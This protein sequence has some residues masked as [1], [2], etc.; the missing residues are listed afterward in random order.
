MAGLDNKISNII[1]TKIPNKILQQLYLRSEKGSSYF[2]DT[3]NLVYLS[4]KTAWARLVSSVNLSSEDMAYFKNKIEID[5]SKPEDLAKNYVLFAGTSKYLNNKYDL[6]SGIGID[7]SYGMLGK[8]EIKEYGYKP[9]PGMTEV[10]IETQGRLGSI[11]SANI[12]FRC[13]DKDQLDIMDALYFKLGFSMFLEWGHTVYFKSDNPNKLE[14]SELESIDPF[15]ANLSKETIQERIAE[16]NRKTEGNYDAMLGIVTNFNYSY[17]Q[18]GGFDCTLKLMS[19]GIL[20]DTI[21]INNTGILPN[22][23]KEEIKLYADTLALIEKKAQEEEARQNAANNPP[24]TVEQIPPPVNFQNVVNEN[25]SSAFINYSSTSPRKSGFENI[26]FSPKAKN[27]DSLLGIRKLQ[28]L[29]PIGN[30][31]YVRTTK[32]KFDTNQLLNL[33]NQFKTKLLDVRNWESSENGLAADTWDFSYNYVSRANYNTYNVK[34]RAE[35]MAKVDSN[36]LTKNGIESILSADNG[37]FEPTLDTTANKFGSAIGNPDNEYTLSISKPVALEYTLKTL[38][39]DRLKN[40][41]E[42]LLGINFKVTYEIEK[43]VQ[44]KPKTNAAQQLVYEG[45]KVIKV[46]YYQEMEF[47]FN[48]TFLLSSISTTSLIK[49][50]DDFLANQKKIAEQNKKQ[51]QE[52]PPPVEEPSITPEQSA[53]SISSQSSLELTL[54]SIQLHSLNK[55]INKIQGSPDL[56]IGKLVYKSEIWNPNDKTSSGQT[57]LS[58]IFSKGVFTPFI[59]SIVN[60]EIANSEEYKEYISKPTPSDYQRLKVQAAYGFASAIMKNKLDATNIGLLKPVNFKELLTAYVVPYEISQEI[61]NGTQANHPVYIPFG[62]LLMILNHCSIVYDKN[63]VKQDQVIKPLV[64]IDFNPNH[65][66]CL[67][68]PK[69]I[70][71]NPFKILIPCEATQSDFAE[72]FDPSVLDQNKKN[73]KSTEGNTEVQPLFLTQQ[74]DDRLSSQIPT[75]RFDEQS[76]NST[77]AYRGKIMNIL[78]S[79]DY[80]I[81]LIQEFSNKEDYNNVYLKQFLDKIIEDINKYTGNFNYFRVSYNDFANTYQIIDDQLVPPP[82]SD[83][84]II[85]PTPTNSNPNDVA[86]FSTLPLVG[87]KSIAK[88]LSITTNISSKLSNMIA[89]SA[90]ANVEDKSVLSSQSDNV[91]FINYKLKDRYIIN[92]TEVSNNKKENSSETTDTLKAAAAQFNSTIRDFYSSINPSEANVAQATNYYIEK[93]TKVKNNELATRASAMIPVSV[94]FTTDGI[95]G[96]NMGQAFTIPKELL[97][98]TYND[99][100]INEP[101][102]DNSR[103][104]KVG[105]FIVGLTHNISENTWNT[106]I[107]ANMTFLKNVTDFSGSVQELRKEALSFIGESAAAGGGIIGNV[108]LGDLNLNSDWINL[109]ADMLRKF[110]GFATKAYWDVNAYRTGYGTDNIVDENGNVSKVTSTTVID[111]ATAERTLKYDINNRFLPEIKNRI[112]ANNWESLTNVQKAAIVSY[113]Y[114]AGAG[115]LNT[116]GIS[117]AIKQKKSPQEIA[118]LIKVG[119]IT[120]KGKILKVLVDRRAQEAAIYLS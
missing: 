111:R 104:H 114:N 86:V 65:N 63:D 94:D 107:K 32:I 87:T 120:A 3:N 48:D 73:I 97:P 90:N 49:Q 2:R 6:R 118:N 85:N 103:I 102:L 78:L 67:S 18:D 70:S 23:L 30:E 108:N 24:P 11:R 95:S 99:R 35:K 19:L 91:G 119:P 84:E 38:Y 33:T 106:S 8:N 72:L 55:A 22:I 28:A 36:F 13:W 54:K 105:F 34:I 116:W 96:L 66:F 98:Y 47:T 113:S 27:V 15:E 112:G 61:A 83:E 31:D 68:N 77:T 16:K 89:I 80:I 1:G 74:G 5:I 82:S 9:M 26:I 14:Y 37:N 52:S 109:T 76:T 7:G 21:K 79:I 50:P 100:S 57:F 40:E 29:I 56:S 12:Q 43:Q 20:G 117:E 51:V 44:Y 17:N 62:F 101:G 110:E 39:K 115:A 59:S 46:P 42:I 88:A 81:N 93:L 75:F 69:Q 64:Y 92:R 71:T 58:Q 10:I 45:P 25:S 60:S 41:I 53:N 4:N